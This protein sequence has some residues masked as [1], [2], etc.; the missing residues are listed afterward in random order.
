[1]KKTTDIVLKDTSQIHTRV[2]REKQIAD[3]RTRERIVT[4]YRTTTD[5]V[6]LDGDT[7]LIPYY[8]PERREEEMRGADLL[9]PDRFLIV[10]EKRLRHPIGQ[11]L[12]VVA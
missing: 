6:F 4:F 2:D 12:A 5:T 10:F 7:V 11:S 8:F 1:M 3:T 9:I